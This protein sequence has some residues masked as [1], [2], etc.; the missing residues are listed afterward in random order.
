MSLCQASRS[1]LGPLR[2]CL[3]HVCLSN[4]P[5]PPHSSG[6]WEGV[7]FAGDQDFNYGL[8]STISRALAQSSLWFDMG[9]VRVRRAWH[10]QVAAG[11]EQN[12]YPLQ[13]FLARSRQPGF[14]EGALLPFQMSCT[15]C[16]VLALTSAC[17]RACVCAQT[18]LRSS[19]LTSAPVFLLSN[20]LRVRKTLSKE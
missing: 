14:E 10:Q 6:V 13:G 3:P 12:V 7:V 18:H 16:K 19:A 1:F 11:H 5:L 20:L 8:R 2:P 15:T 4:D 9:T 17:V